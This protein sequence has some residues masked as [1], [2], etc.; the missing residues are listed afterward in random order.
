M[1]NT[2]CGRFDHWDQIITLIANDQ[3]RFD[4]KKGQLIKRSE[5]FRGHFLKWQE[6]ISDEIIFDVDG[7]NLSNIVQYIIS[8]DYFMELKG[9]DIN[10]QFLHLVDFLLIDNHVEDLKNLSTIHTIKAL[11]KQFD[12]L[13]KETKFT[14]LKTLESIISFTNIDEVYDCTREML[15]DIKIGK[16]SNLR[17]SHYNN[18]T[19]IAILEYGI[20]IM[21]I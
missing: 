1:I 12:E 4:V 17:K 8:R 13:N 10:N 16:I 14:T 15:N 18:A 3:K 5:Y 9:D 21:R 7:H 20:E 11:E 6:K 19:Y 2:E